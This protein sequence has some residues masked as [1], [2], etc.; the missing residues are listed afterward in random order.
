MACLSN[1]LPLFE[2]TCSHHVCLGC[3]YTTN[4][5]QCMLCKCDLLLKT[6]DSTP[7]FFQNTSQVIIM[8]TVG[9]NDKNLI[10]ISIIGEHMDSFIFYTMLWS[11]HLFLTSSVDIV[12]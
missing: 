4:D 2:R 7:R 9:V 8:C 6:Q 10:K 1:D 3:W 5:G 11:K 12:A